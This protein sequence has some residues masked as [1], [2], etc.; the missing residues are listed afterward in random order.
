MRTIMIFALHNPVVSILRTF[1]HMIH[2][3][4][5]SFANRSDLDLN[6]ELVPGVNDQARLQ[7]ASNSYCIA[8][9]NVSAVTQQ[10]RLLIT[11]TPALMWKSLV[12][13]GVL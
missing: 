5:V 10:P 6:S 12:F 7:S 8:A 11:S 13:I 4:A 3:I 2:A 9:S 1:W